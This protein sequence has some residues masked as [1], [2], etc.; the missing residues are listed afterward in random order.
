MIG[1]N[2]TWNMTSAENIE[3]YLEAINTPK[4][5]M[6]KM[7]NV[8][9]NLKTNPKMYVMEVMIN[10]N[11]NTMQ[12]KVFINGELKH[13]TGLITFNTPI[14]M[15]GMDGR[16]VTLTVNPESNTKL[17]MNKTAPNFTA[18]ITYTLNGNEVTTTRTSNGVTC[19]ETY[20]K[21]TTT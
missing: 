9:S 11:N 21:M 8:I 1:F 12:T 7:L 4:E 20:K 3:T 16:V 14:E 15:T 5:F 6:T 18:N 2:G 10:K 19:T 13:D 17:V